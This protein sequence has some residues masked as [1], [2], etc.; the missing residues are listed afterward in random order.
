MQHKLCLQIQT[1]MAEHEQCL[2]VHFGQ[3]ILDEKDSCAILQHFE[4]TTDSC[5]CPMCT[6]TRGAK[7]FKVAHL[8]LWT[9]THVDPLLHT[10]TAATE[11]SFH[12]VSAHRK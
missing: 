7:E 10:S 12:D 3:F 11:E 9:W 5:E 4:A 8:E 2:V 1:K 6:F